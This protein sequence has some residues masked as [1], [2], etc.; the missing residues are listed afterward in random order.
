MKTIGRNSHCPCGSRK[1]Y[2]HCCLAEHQRLLYTE[3]DRF[4]MRLAIRGLV[5]GPLEQLLAPWRELFDPIELELDDIHDPLHIEYSILSRQVLHDWLVFDVVT[6]GV[7]AVD[8]LLDP[9]AP[10][11]AGQRAY[12][13]AMSR[14]TMRLYEV[15]AAHPGT[16]LTLRDLFGDSGEVTVHSRRASRSLAPGDLP[17]AR[18]VTPGPWGRPVIEGGLLP[19]KNSRREVILAHLRE[20]FAAL[21]EA[22]PETSITDFFKLMPPYF[23][24]EWAHSLPEHTLDGEELMFTTVLFSLTDPA[25]VTALLDAHPD[26]E[27]QPGGPRWFLYGVKRD[28]PEDHLA[29]VLVDDHEL[30]LTANTL[31]RGE[32]GRDLLATYLGELAAHQ[33]TS[34]VRPEDYVAQLAALDPPAQGDAGDAAGREISERAAS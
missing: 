19:L 5:E 21:R 10:P 16:S 3:D 1:K 23:H 17:A 29:R 26:L 14:S 31:G 24:A 25:R 13:T 22:R 27:R 33:S 28:D 7:R 8:F 30:V 2:K 9:D 4:A 11:D 12:L 15:A 20:T 34:A 18:I 32:R 6:D